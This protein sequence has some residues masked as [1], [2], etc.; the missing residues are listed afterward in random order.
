MST[1]I[2]FNFDRINQISSIYQCVVNGY[3]RNC[4]FLLPSNNSYYNIPKLVNYIILF[5]YQSA[6]VFTLYGSG[7]N[8][9]TNNNII[10]K[11]NGLSA[12]TAYGNIDIRANNTQCR[13][14]WIIKILSTE[15]G[16]VYIGVD[17]SN[18]IHLHTN[19][20]ISNASCYY[21]YGNGRKYSNE[22]P[23]GKLYGYMFYNRFI[24]KMEINTK[25]KTLKY[26]TNGIDEGIAFQDINFKNT[27][28]HLAITMQ[29]KND[30]VQIIKFQQTVIE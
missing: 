16:R 2:R 20:T 30:S 1:Q 3:V 26:Y 14:L 10:T 19:Y 12:E 15:K 13:Y 5:Y 11:V 28:Y 8:F 27:T 24:I 7:M 9:D 17:S 25:Q 29:D 22:L 6:E 18:K 4:R 21:S 23:G